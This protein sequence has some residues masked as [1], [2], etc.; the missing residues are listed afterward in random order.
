MGEALVLREFS[1]T[2]GGGWWGGG[3]VVGGWGGGWGE[4]LERLTHQVWHELKELW[5]EVSWREAGER[6]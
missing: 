3:M 5:A 6:G 1:A 4:A 2:C